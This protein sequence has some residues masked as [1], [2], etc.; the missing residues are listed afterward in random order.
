MATQI[1]MTFSRDRYDG[2]AALQYSWVPEGKRRTILLDAGQQSYTQTD[3]VDDDIYPTQV[4]VY[5]L[6]NEDAVSTTMWQFP[7]GPPHGVIAGAVIAVS[8]IEGRAF[9]AVEYRDG[10][11]AEDVHALDP[12][13]CKCP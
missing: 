2:P 9:G 1:T 10:G 11:S 8:E 13:G 4:Q 3:T 7:S 5:C 6:N 12:F